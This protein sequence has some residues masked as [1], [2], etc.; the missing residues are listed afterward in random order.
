MK[1][2]A[3]CVVVAAVGAGCEPPK[4]VPE[5]IPKAAPGS[6]EPLVPT[7]SDP[8]AKAYVEKAVRA[9]TGDKPELALKGNVSR[10]T[11]K[12]R[13]LDPAQGVLIDVTRTLAAVWPDRFAGTD[14]QQARGL[15]VAISGYLRRPR[16]SLTRDGSP[17]P[18][19][20]PA[21]TERNFVGDEIAQH[22]MALLVPLT[23]PKAILYDFQS[24]TG[25]AP[26]TGEPLAIHLVKLKLPGGPVYT[27]TFEAKRDLL[28]RVEYELT[29]QGVRRRRMWTVMEHK[30]GPDGLTLP[31]KV[32]LW[33]DG[34]MVEQVEVEKW[35]FPAN[36]PDSEFDPP[37]K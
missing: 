24:V 37:K 26:L 10:A 33:Q 17:V 9:F 30:R 20:N 34:R 32:E 8:A 12:G 35:E 22:W 2:L 28:L 14:V 18:L 11:L 13:Q 29:E 31:H 7:A 27:L 6:T 4:E 36:I 15:T 23:D 21:E 5:V 1:R 25:T 19:P 3:V 16:L